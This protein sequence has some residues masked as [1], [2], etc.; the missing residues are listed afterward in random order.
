MLN[1]L[2]EGKNTGLRE[3]E[4]AAVIAQLVAAV[5][6]AG[7]GDELLD[8]LGL[9]IISIALSLRDCRDNATRPGGRDVGEVADYTTRH[10]ADRTA[11]EL[12]RRIGPRRDLKTKAPVQQPAPAAR[13]R[14]AIALLGDVCEQTASP[15]ATEA[16]AGK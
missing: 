5:E 8:V 6:R 12:R 14:A 4:K 3:R 13:R 2:V 11:L 7:R 1:C 9:D 10:A 15:P 16:D